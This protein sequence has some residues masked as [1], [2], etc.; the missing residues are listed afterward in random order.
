MTP[1]G[2]NKLTP[3]GNISRNETTPKDVSNKNP[4]IKNALPKSAQ[5]P[6]SEL[7]LGG[8]K[9]SA[10]SKSVAEFKPILRDERTECAEFLSSLGFD[11]KT[12]EVFGLEEVLD[13]NNFQALKESELRQVLKLSD[14]QCGAFL[15][16][17]NRREMEWKSPRSPQPVSI[18][19]QPGLADCSNATALQSGTSAKIDHVGT[20]DLSSIAAHALQIKTLT[21]SSHTRRIAIKLTG[22]NKKSGDCAAFL[23]EFGF[24]KH[25]NNMRKE[26][27]LDWDT[28]YCLTDKE[29][30]DDFGF[31]AEEIEIYRL[32]I[33]TVFEKNRKSIDDGHI[34][35]AALPEIKVNQ[36]IPDNPDYD[37][38]GKIVTPFFVCRDD[39]VSRLCA[40]IERCLDMDMPFV[41]GRTLG[42]GA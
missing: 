8:G 12:I 39:Y 16:A 31:T 30:V 7:R 24:D 17:I 27:C 35:T 26:R 14:G 33:S 36:N 40:L 11:H 13:W 28:M 37:Y 23:T 5:H 18:G 32:G 10:G 21:S 25:I 42:K 3:T 15:E 9:D 34:S 29:L 41:V 19:K 20:Q 22:L 4:D 6:F 1:S 38:G 2:S